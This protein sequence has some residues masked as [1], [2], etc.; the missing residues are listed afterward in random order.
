[1]A[2]VEP[3]VR[4]RGWDSARAESISAMRR[5]IASWSPGVA[6]RRAEAKI[7]SAGAVLWR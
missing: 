2:K 4:L 7:Q 1:L 3:P 6:R 5:A